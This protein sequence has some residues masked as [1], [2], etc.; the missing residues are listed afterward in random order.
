MVDA[1]TVSGSDRCVRV[2]GAEQGRGGERGRE[3]EGGAWGRDGIPSQLQAVGGKQEE[4]WRLAR[5]CTISLLCLLAEVGDDWHGPG[6]PTQPGKW[7][8]AFLSLS[9]PFNSV[10]LFF[11]I[12][13]AL[14]KIA[15]HFQKS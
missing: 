1:V 15:R 14:L 10:F 5:A 3:Q 9:F 8:V 11:Y 12:C 6:G 13:W 7:P 4:A 2:R